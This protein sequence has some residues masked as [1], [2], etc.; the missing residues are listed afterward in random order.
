M[1]SFQ[2]RPVLH[3]EID[4]NSLILRI[5]EH[6]EHQHESKNKQKLI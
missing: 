2:E 4:I 1:V 3:K 6:G 5:T